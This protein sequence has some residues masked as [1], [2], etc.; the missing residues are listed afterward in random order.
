ML[1]RLDPGS[2]NGS[3]V[4]YESL[5]LVRRLSSKM[6]VEACNKG[7]HGQTKAYNIESYSPIST[8]P[9]ETSARFQTVPYE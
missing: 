9:N 1:G 5:H 7:W 3:G 6:R 8:S 2:L 4:E